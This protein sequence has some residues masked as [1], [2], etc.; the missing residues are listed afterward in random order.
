VPGARCINPKTYPQKK[1]DGTK[2]VTPSGVQSANIGSSDW[3]ERIVLHEA[4]QTLFAVF[5]V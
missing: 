2:E 4:S 5:M 1:A 3:C